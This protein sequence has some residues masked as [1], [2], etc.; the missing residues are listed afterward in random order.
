MKRN[1]HSMRRAA[2]RLL[3]ATVAGAFLASGAPVRAVDTCIT[4]DPGDVYYVAYQNSPAGP[5]YI[6]D[7]GSKDQ[8]LNATTHLTFPDIRSADFSTVFTPT[9]P[10]LW[11]GFF[12]V[13][14]PV[15][16][17]AIVSANGPKD[18]FA[19]DNSSIIGAAQQIDSWATGL[20]QSANEIGGPP[21][22]LNAGTFPGRVFGSYQDTLNGAS[23]GRIAGNLV[24][25]VETRLSNSAG[26]RTATAKVK[27]FGSQS[28]PALG[29]SSRTSLGYFKAFTDG[30][31]EYWP[32]FDGDLLPDVAIGSDP[33]ADKCPG[34]ASA[35]NTDT[36]SDNRALPCDCNDAD[37]TVWAIPNEIAGLAIAA[38]KTT[39]IWSLPSAPGGTAI[40]YDVFRGQQ[41]APGVAP[42]YTC[43]SP[44]Q[45]GTSVTDAT[46]PAVGARP[47]FYLVRA[48][49]NCGEGTVGVGQNAPARTVPSCP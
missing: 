1:E 42:V 20:A 37:A 44:N 21:C 12:G 36:D 9:S 17:D 46:A 39:I 24:W 18:Q 3:V 28:N 29:T 22:S 11:I 26:T 38:N 25:N 31:A 48:Q 32:D 47:F 13:S 14:N 6:V 40:T 33:E 5:E 15:T 4:P 45:A 43:L 10:N 2:A 16:R 34:V 8:F 30:T 19:L 7:L 35:D 23:Q 41:A 27:F 49:T